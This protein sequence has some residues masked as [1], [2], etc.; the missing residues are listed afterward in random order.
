MQYL[1]SIQ[2]SNF[3]KN[4]VAASS[5]PPAKTILKNITAST[6]RAADKVREVTEESPQKVRRSEKLKRLSKLR[7]Q[8]SGI[9]PVQMKKEVA[10]NCGETKSNVRP[11]SDVTEGI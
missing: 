8:N 3:Q 6:T 4:R 11:V 9:L 2:S 7:S 5:P 10:E 1:S